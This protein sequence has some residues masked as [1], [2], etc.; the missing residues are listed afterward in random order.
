MDVSMK[1][2]IAMWLLAVAGL[3]LLSQEAG[4]NGIVVSNSF[5]WN[6][7]LGQSNVY[8]SVDI[9]WSNAW[10]TAANWDAAWV[11]VKFKGPGSNDWQH[12]TLSAN[13]SDHIMP[14]GCTNTAAPDGTKELAI[15][16]NT[17]E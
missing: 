11:F 17:K 12:A 10:R 5:L 15:A 16:H 2:R 8:V 14:A 13:S 3:V 7:S 6:P 9:S 4:A 1:R